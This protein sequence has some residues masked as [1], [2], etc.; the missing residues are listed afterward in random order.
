MIIDMH[1]H[2]W[3]EDMPSRSWWDSFV[4]VSASLAGRPEEKIRQ[5]LPGWMDGTGDLIIEDMNAAGIDKSV[6]L[7]ID[8]VIGGG[9]GD[10]ATLDAQHEM[11]ARAVD[12]FPDRRIAFDGHQNRGQSQYQGDV[13]DVAAHHVAHC[14]HAFALDRRHQADHHFGCR[15]AEGHHGQADDDGCD[16]QTAGEIRRPFDEPFGTV[17][18]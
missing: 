11:Y 17:V 10:V 2:L 15:R 4:Q 16:A 12:K 3:R 9:T 1:C 8:Y 7:P 5:R 6:L 13:E 14:D 18:E